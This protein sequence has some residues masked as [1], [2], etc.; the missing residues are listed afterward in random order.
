MTYLLDTSALLAHYRQEVGWEAVQALFD[1]Q[2]AHIAVS[3]IS[4]AE[5]SRRTTALGVPR[6]VTRKV[7]G[8]YV[9]LMDAVCDIDSET[10]WRAFDLCMKIRERLPLVDALIAA[11]AGVRSACLVHCDRHFDAIPSDLVQTLPIG[12]K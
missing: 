3:C 11:T 9:S 12:R 6:E 5:M 1:D 7:V 8:D 2:L 4:I 10:A